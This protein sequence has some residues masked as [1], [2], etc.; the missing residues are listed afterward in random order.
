MICGWLQPEETSSNWHQARG[1]CG[2]VEAD[3]AV[4]FWLRGALN[5]GD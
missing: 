2:D 5:Q 3:A 4:E 1:V